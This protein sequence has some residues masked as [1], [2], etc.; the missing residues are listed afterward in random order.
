MVQSDERPYRFKRA[1]MDTSKE[2]VELNLKKV[3][4]PIKPIPGLEYCGVKDSSDKEE[5]LKLIPGVYS[6]LKEQVIDLPA[7]TNVENEETGV[8]ITIKDRDTDRD[9]RMRQMA[10]ASRFVGRIFWQRHTKTK[11]T[12]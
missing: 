8:P 4:T 1:H 2:E 7:K 10:L 6:F 9:K 11:R 5:K 12:R 3:T